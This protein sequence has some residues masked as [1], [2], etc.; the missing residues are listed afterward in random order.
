MRSN[1]RPTLR[2]K[3]FIRDGYDETGQPNYVQ[4]EEIRYS[5]VNLEHGISQTSIRADKSGSK[6]RAEEPVRTGRI[7]VSPYDTV[8]NGDLLIIRGMQ[9]RVS[10]VKYRYDMVGKIHHF[11]VDLTTWE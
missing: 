6:S 9:W 10:A 1:F 8:E 5:V 4:S 11:Q 2:A 7:L 3:K